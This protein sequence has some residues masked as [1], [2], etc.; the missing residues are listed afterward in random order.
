MNVR[1]M[2]KVGALAVM[3]M[4]A[5]LL[6]QEPA[7]E[8]VGV[9]TLPAITIA[10]AQNGGLPVSV[11][12]DRGLLLGGVGSDLWHGADMPQDEFWMITDRGPN[13]QIRVDDANRRTFPISEFTPHIVRVR[14][15]GDAIEVL[16]ALPIVNGE[17]VAVTG[18]SNLEGHDEKPWDYSAQVELSYNQDGLDT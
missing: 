18:L 2:G 16:E 12:N 4:S 7:G 6:A 10:D 13:G 1:L 5:V 14:I 17:G 15:A 3:A 11:T 9:Y 8:V